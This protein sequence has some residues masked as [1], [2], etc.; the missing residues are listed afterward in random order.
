MINNFDTPIWKMPLFVKSGA[1]IP[2]TNPNNNVSG[3]RADYR[4]FELYPDGVT[5]FEVYD[6]DGRTQEY[7]KGAA[8][9]T[10]VRSEESDGILTVTVFPTKGG[11]EGFVP[12]KLTEFRINATSRPSKVSVKEGGKTLKLSEAASMEDF[13]SRDNVWSILASR[14][15]AVC[16]TQEIP[17]GRSFGADESSALS[18]Q[19]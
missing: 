16:R 18:R 9:L 5:E 2:M 19:F 10:P 4:A 11:F 15:Q 13:N 7:L 6:D 14:F 1:I 17:Q 8:S 12:E 3:I